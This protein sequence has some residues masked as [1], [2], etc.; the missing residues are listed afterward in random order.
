MACTFIGTVQVNYCHSYASVCACAAKHTVVT[1]YVC[2]CEFCSEHICFFRGLWA[3]VSVSTDIIPC[4]LSMQ[5][6]DLQN[7]ALIVF[8][9]R[10]YLLSSKAFVNTYNSSKSKAVFSRLSFGLKY[11]T[12]Q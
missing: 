2:V 6:A 9:I 11:G 12:V 1:L 10:Q 8:E 3:K 5:F 4:F 7:K